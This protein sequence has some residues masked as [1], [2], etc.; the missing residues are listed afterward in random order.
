M[1]SKKLDEIARGRIGQCPQTSGVNDKLGDDTV[2]MSWKRITITKCQSGDTTED[3]PAKSVAGKRG[4]GGGRLENSFCA[5][6]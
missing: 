3:L 4:K 1:L 5:A 6:T 2:E